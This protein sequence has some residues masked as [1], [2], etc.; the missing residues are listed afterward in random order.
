[1]KVPAPS[2]APMLRSDTQGRLLARILADPSREHTLSELVEWAQ[3]SMPTV[4]REIG[5]AERAGIVS[6]RK[7]GPARVVRAN[8]QH[9]LYPAVRQ[10]ILGTYGPPEIVARQFAGVD[11][12]D[13]VVLFGSWAARYLGHPGRVPNDIDV[14]VIGEVDHDEVDD[15]SERVEREIGIPVQATVRS[16]SAWRGEQESFIREVKSRPLV[17]V[18][19]D[20]A[21]GDLAEELRGL[22]QQPRG[23]R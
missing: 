9:P 12:A 11:R 5:R 16:R 14:L 17:P 7:V 19:V 18:L 1:M 6:S 13:A 21:E 3:S 10:L 22:Q 20:E 2:L 8:E 4:Q 15:A 23:P